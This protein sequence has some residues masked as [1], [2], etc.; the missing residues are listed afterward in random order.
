M[1]FFLMTVLA[2][3]ALAAAGYAQL[4]IPRFTA[5]PAK[6]TLTRAI[7]IVVGLASGYV[8][9]ASYGTDLLLAVLAFLIGFGTVHV[10]A[11]LILLIKREGRTGKS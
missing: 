8:G 4:A 7:L 10:P 6:A 11:A 9:A 2:L 1:N 5:G 3:V